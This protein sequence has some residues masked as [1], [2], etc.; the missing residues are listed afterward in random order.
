VAGNDEKPPPIAE[1]TV[2]RAMEAYRR[3][4]LD[5]LAAF[6]HPEAEIEMFLLGGEA[7]RG[8]E[9]LRNALAAAREGIHRPTMS[10]LEAVADDAVVMAGRIQ[11]MD[12]EGAVSDRAAFWLT[13]LRDGKVWRTRVLT[14]LAEAPAAYEA[15]TGR[16]L[17]LAAG[18]P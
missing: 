6:V 11:T 14:T 4:D 1:Q 16:S 13:V 17:D 15:L 2:A 9:A 12:A 10:S 8:P 3:G 7:A 18:V 5:G